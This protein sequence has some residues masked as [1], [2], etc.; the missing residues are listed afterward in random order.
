ME[1]RFK[2]PVYKLVNFFKKSRDR[3]KERAK[4]SIQDIKGYKKRIEFL[5]TSKASLKE[6]NKELMKK[7]QGKS[8]EL[9]Q[10]PIQK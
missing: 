5:E 6:K 8:D 2:S 9:N 1:D 4:K 10:S 3:W 7:L